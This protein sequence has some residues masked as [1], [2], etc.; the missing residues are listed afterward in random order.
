[1]LSPF[2]R[3]GISPNA[4]L[5]AIL[6]DVSSKGKSPSRRRLIVKRVLSAGDD[7]LNRVDVVRPK[8]RVSLSMRPRRA[9]RVRFRRRARRLARGR[10]GR[11]WRIPFDDP[12]THLELTMIHEVM[13]LDH[14]GPALGM[15]LYGAALKLF[16]FAALIV[17]LAVPADFGTPW[18]DC[19]PNGH[20]PVS[21]L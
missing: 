2:S 7:P 1:M 16:L 13:V 19:S 15:I 20:Q 6:K 12:N 11:A 14:S 10:G 3:F 21:E 17:R 9:A 5:G 18:F 4:R 8:P